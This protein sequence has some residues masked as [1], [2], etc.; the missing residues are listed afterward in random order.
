MWAAGLV[1]VLTIGVGA[2]FGNRLDAD[3]ALVRSPLIGR[4]APARALPLLDGGGTLSLA[5]L[6][7]QVVLV[8]FWASW[9]G[10][11]R[12]EHPDLLAAAKTYADAGVTVV[13]VSYQDEPRAATA[14]LDELGRGEAPGY[15]YVTDPGSSAAVDF[16]VFGIPETFVVDREGTIVGKMTGATSFPVLAAAIDEVLAGRRPPSSILGTL[17]PAA[18]AGSR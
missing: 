10:P 4:P 2:L 17:Q 12:Q 7:G 5:D 11:C 15:R 6:R 8:N 14:L 16:G 1:A 18:P 3:P 13:G 9:C